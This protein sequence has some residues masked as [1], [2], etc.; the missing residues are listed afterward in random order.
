MSKKKRGTLEERKAQ[1]SVD[2]TRSYQNV[3][4]SSDGKVVLYDLLKTGYFLIT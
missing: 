1:L 3:F 4:N 2:T